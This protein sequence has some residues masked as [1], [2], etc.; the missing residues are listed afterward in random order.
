MR[1]ELR[2]S[3]IG[4]EHVERSARF[5]LHR[6]ADLYKSPACILLNNCAHMW[7]LFAS[8]ATL[9]GTIH[10]RSYPISR[11]SHAY[12]GSVNVHVKRRNGKNHAIGAR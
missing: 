7:R 9:L 6:T 4:F 3:A 12:P 10:S 5:R 8:L 1:R 11:L 2:W